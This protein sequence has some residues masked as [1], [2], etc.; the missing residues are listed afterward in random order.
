MLPCVGIEDWPDFKSR[1]FLHDIT[2]GKVP[3]LETL[4]E[5]ADRLSFYK[6]NQLQHHT[7]DVSNPQ[8]LQLVCEMIDEFLP[9]FSSDKFNICCD[10]TFDLGRGRNKALAEEMGRGKLYLYFVNRIIKHVKACNKSVMMWE[11]ILLKYPQVLS[12]LPEDIIR[13]QP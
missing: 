9:L 12:E 3:R 6:V 13:L 2:R 1:G 11:D 5:L 7:L 10:E 4:K 8:S